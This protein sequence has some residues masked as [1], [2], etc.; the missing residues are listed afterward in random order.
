VILYYGRMGDEYLSGK[1]EKDK[2]KDKVKL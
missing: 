2:G 1:W